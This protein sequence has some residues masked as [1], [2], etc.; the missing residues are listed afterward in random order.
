[1]ARSNVFVF[2]A[3]WD[4]REEMCTELW[5]YMMNLMILP[6]ELTLTDILPEGVAENL[7]AQL[8]TYGYSFEDISRF[9]PHTILFTFSNEFFTLN[10]DLEWAYA[11]EF[12]V[13]DF[14]AE[15]NI[16]TL[17]LSDHFAFYDLLL[18]VPL[19]MQIHALE[20]FPDLDTVLAADENILLSPIFHHVNPPIFHSYASRITEL[21]RETDEPTTFFIAP[22]IGDTFYNAGNDFEYLLSLL[23]NEGFE[24]TPLWQNALPPVPEIITGQ[25]EFRILWVGNS[26]TYTGDI[27][28]QVSDIANLHDL[29][30][31]QRRITQ[32]GATL[33]DLMNEVLENLRENEYD[34]VILQDWADRCLWDEAAFMND[35]RILSAA[36]RSAGA[37]PILYNPAFRHPDDWPDVEFQDALTAAYSN[38]AFLNG[39]LFID[40]ARAWMFA[41]EQHPG[42]DLFREGGHHASNR[43]A[44]FTA[45]VFASTLFDIQVTEVLSTAVYDS[46]YVEILG[47]TAWEFVNA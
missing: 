11:V 26:H 24:L 13:R 30:V 46:E 22:A 31:F 23:E 38:A 42:L 47:Q 6:D 5:D 35:V 20:N 15:N 19:E 16:P 10:T 37:I 28:R 40:A 17:S 1:M 36:A 2:E 18:D 29:I 9:S 7:L 4:T 21:L 8:P 34:Y 41:Y 33:G 12:Y 39:A 14:A 32:P 27:P 43:G 25:N 3:E 44:F 45:A